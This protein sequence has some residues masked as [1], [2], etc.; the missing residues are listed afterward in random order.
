[1]LTGKH[2]SVKNENDAVLNLKQKIAILQSFA[3]EKRELNSEI[4]KDLPRSLRQFNAWTSSGRF[5]ENFVFSANAAATLR[6]NSTITAQVLALINILR[7]KSS[8]IG[9]GKKLSTEQLLKHQLQIEQSRCKVVEHE[10]V[11][12]RLEVG[13][14]E[15]RN[16]TLA[17]RLSNVESEASEQ[18]STRD[19][20]IAHLR[21]ENKE[22]IA[23]FSKLVLIQ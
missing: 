11:K 12:S 13:K 7:E 6:N 2:I 9:R 16:R 14:L 15:K 8:L 20:L 22:L 17:T 23:K 19:N 21:H 1:M 3:D 4:L 10:Y 18:I 5:G